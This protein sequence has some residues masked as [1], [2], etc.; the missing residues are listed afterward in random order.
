MPMPMQM[1]VVDFGKL[2]ADEMETWGKLIRT[3]NIKPE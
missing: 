2:I 1:A 3:A